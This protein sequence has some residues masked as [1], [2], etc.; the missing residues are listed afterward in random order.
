MGCLFLIVFFFFSSRR[1]HTRWN[2]DW[3]SDVCSSDLRS[4]DVESVL[5]LELLTWKRRPDSA[6]MGS[7]SPEDLALLT[8][9]E[10]RAREATRSPV[11]RALLVANPASRLGRRR[12]PRAVE[13]LR[14]AG[15]ECDVA[16]TERPGH[17]EQL[18]L[19]RSGGYDAVFT[20][21]GD[22]TA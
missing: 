8:P 11:K 21:G 1:R 6:A 3:S 2:C 20:L 9:S 7:V 13:A 19:E 22:G 14:K 15:V 12:L 16:F 17:A 10:E 4:V 18:V 5:P